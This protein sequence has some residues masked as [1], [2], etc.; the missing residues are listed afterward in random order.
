MKHFL[1]TQDWSRAELD[2]LLADAA[3][4]KQHKLGDALKGKSIALVFFNPSMRTRTRWM[5][6]PKNISPKSRRDLI[7]V[8][9]FPKF[10]DWSQDREDSVL[11]S[12]AKYSPVPVINMETITHPCQE[13]AEYRRC[14]F[15]AD[16]RHPHGHGCDLIM[17]D[18][19][20]YSR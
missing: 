10:V 1:N 7:G 20:L 2:T 19:G 8:R 18:P 13:L 4:F 3:R 14:Q 12:F 6:I 15:R 17:P 5:A 11:K 16:H 9:A